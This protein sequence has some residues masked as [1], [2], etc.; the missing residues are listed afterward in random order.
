MDYEMHMGTKSDYLFF[1]SSRLL[2]TSEIQLLKNQCDQE[3]TQILTI[4]LLSLENPGLAGHM[5]TENR[6]MFLETDGSL[7]WLYHCPLIHSPL[8]TMNECYD[9]IPILYEGQIQFVDSITRQTNPAAKIQNCTGRIKNLFQ[10]EMHQEDSWYTLTPGI[11]NQLRPAVFGLKD[12]SPVAV[13]SF[14][15]SQDAG[16][17]TRSELSSFWDSILISAAS[18]NALKKFSQK[19]TVFSNNNKN[20]DSFPYYSPRTDFYVDNMISTGYFK[21]RFMDTFGPVAYVLEHCRIYFSVFSFFKLI[22]DVVVVVIRQLKITKMTGA[23]LGFGKTLLSA[24]Y[25][26]SL[27][28]ILTSMYNPRAPTLAAVGEE[29][30]TLCNEEELHDMRDD[31]K[32]K[33]EQIHPVMGPAQFNQAVTPISSV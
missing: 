11:V 24:S 29:R 12:V 17:Y 26:I 10:F 33:E 22:I 21:D 30:K 20:P 5:L 28:S 18:R 2:Q 25:N 13:H 3:R 6:S 27:M 31:T 32:K 9:R 4:L 15:G 7:A 1:Q 8:H 19:L 16:M 14:P 23:S